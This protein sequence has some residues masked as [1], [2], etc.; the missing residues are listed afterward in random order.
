MRGLRIVM[1]A[2]NKNLRHMLYNDRNE[3]GTLKTAYERP[4][5]RALALRA[6]PPPPPSALPISGRSPR[7]LHSAPH[8]TRPR[9]HC[10]AEAPDSMISGRINWIE[11][12]SGGG[13]MLG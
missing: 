7:P 10:M 3:D 4:Q 5:A 8:P 9:D 6:T 13:G 1:A 11:I 2:R 12:C